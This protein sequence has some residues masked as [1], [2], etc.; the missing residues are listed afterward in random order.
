L[1]HPDSPG[2][3]AYLE[4]AG[5]PLLR[6]YILAALPSSARSIRTLLAG[7]GAV[8]R[9]GDRPRSGSMIRHRLARFFNHVAR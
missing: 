7:R 6:P 5:D 4:M 1:F 8:D 2:Y 9:G 3:E